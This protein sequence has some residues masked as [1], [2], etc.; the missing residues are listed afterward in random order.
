MIEQVRSVSKNRLG[1]RHGAVTQATM[2]Q[3]SRILRIVL[4]L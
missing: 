3:V 1:R 2:D 4:G